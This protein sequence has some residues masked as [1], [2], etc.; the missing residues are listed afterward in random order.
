MITPDYAALL[1]LFVLTGVGAV[2]PLV[3]AFK[4]RPGVLATL[5]VLGVLVAGVLT[6]AT[7]W[8][9][10]YVT[11]Q[12]AAGNALSVVYHGAPPALWPADPASGTWASASARRSSR[13]ASWS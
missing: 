4:V 6:V 12:D 8:T 3:G 9:I 13:S 5:A 10:P 11:A 7:F 1:P 2:I